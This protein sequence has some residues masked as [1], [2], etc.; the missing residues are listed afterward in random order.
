MGT[1]TITENAKR[2]VVSLLNESLQIEYE[3]MMNYPRC[4][5]VLVNIHK[6]TDEQLISDIKTCGEDSTRHFDDISQLIERLGGK[7]VWK[8]SPI[9]QMDDVSS[10]IADQLKREFAVLAI[11]EGI[12]HILQQNKA[13][14]KGWKFFGK[15]FTVRS[16]PQ[17][18]PVTFNE[19]KN[20]MDIEISD[21]KK[22]IR[23]AEDSIATIRA[24][25]PGITA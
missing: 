21:E 10:R 13:K 14:I 3:F 20:I 1:V 15:T 8:T 12:N 16:E 24:L 7:P 5:E 22:H 23:L 17:E 9:G 18:N 11:F 25:L 2:A 6:I 4:I 19:I